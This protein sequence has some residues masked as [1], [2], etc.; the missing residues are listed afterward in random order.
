[1]KD[2]GIRF[3]FR[4]RRCNKDGSGQYTGHQ[5]QRNHDGMDY[6]LTV[7]NHFYLLVVRVNLF[8]NFQSPSFALLLAICITYGQVLEHHPAN[9]DI[10]PGLLFQDLSTPARNENHSG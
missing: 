4:F 3:G 2:L 6:L 8:V 7:R 1:V 5:E 9:S 10:R